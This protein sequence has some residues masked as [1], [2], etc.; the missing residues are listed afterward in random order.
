MGLAD[1]GVPAARGP[2]YELALT[3]RSY[4]FE[5][6]QP[7]EHNERLEFLGDAIL[8]AVV[9]TFLY[10]VFPDLKEGDLARI[11][12]SVVNSRA[13]A[14]IAMSLGVGDELR[15]GRGEEASGGR[16]KDSLLADTFEALIGA[17][18][19]D[20]GDEAVRAALVPLF[21]PLVRRAADAASPRYDAKTAL[22]E[23]AVRGSGILPVYRIASTGPDHDKHFTA[24]V[25]VDG[26]PCGEGEG[27]T[28]KEA[29]QRAA[30]SAL[31]KLEG[32]PA[33]GVIH[34]RGRRARA[35]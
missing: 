26:E 9:T 4:A 32:R 34:G 11:R 13:L 16:A 3:H 21:E 6:P 5:Q 28:K 8:G 1:L 10:E 30:Q 14:Q 33:G 27:R 31:A 2:I 25:Y 19:L 12:A 35:S 7:I 18:Y 29:E 24:L 22:Q 20:R 17:V 23:T 15:L